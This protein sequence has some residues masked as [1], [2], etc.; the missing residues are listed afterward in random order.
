MHAP[1]PADPAFLV[2]EPV[3]AE[4]LLVPVSRGSL[5]SSAC[6]LACSAWNCRP[7]AAMLN[8]AIFDVCRLPIFTPP[9]FPP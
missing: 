1:A 7:I 6:A 4:I 3:G 8:F 5:R 2:L 9:G